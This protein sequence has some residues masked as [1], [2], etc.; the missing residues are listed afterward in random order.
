MPIGSAMA[1]AISQ[2]EQRQEKGRFGPVEQR[3]G[4]GHV[5]EDRLAEIPLQQLPDI[6]E[7]LNAERAVEAELGAQVGDILGRGVRPEHDRSRVAGRD[8]HDHEDDRD[9]EK[10]HDD[11][12]EEALENVPYHES[13]ILIPGRPQARN[14]TPALMS[15][16]RIDYRTI[17]S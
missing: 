4:H 13:L 11:H 7:V 12:A 9:D 8:A 17:I 1:L 5:E 14:A 6:I 16:P 3:R 2:R 15:R 10:H